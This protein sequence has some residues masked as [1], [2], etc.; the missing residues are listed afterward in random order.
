MAKFICLKVNHT[1]QKMGKREGREKKNVRRKKKCDLTFG[2]LY[3]SL[4][5]NNSYASLFSFIQFSF[6]ISFL[7]FS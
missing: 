4:D 2:S 1:Q 6:L 5:K 3:I 7:S